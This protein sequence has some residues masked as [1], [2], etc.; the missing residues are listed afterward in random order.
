MGLVPPEPGFLA[1]LREAADA[2]GALLV[3]DEVISGFRVARGGAQEREGVTPDLTRA[4][5]DHRRRAAGRG[6]CRAARSDGADRAGGRRLPGGHA[7]GQPAGHRGRPRHAAPA[8]RRRLRAPG[9]AS[10]SALAD[11]PRAA[12]AAAGVP[13]QVAHTTGLL[14]LFFSDGA[15]RDYADAAALRPRAPT[16]PSAARMLDARGVPAAVAVRGLVPVARPRRRA[17]RAHARR[18]PRGV[19]GGG[20]R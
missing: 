12:A 9:R 10:R 6:L 8:R 19:R 3:F 13:V 2:A 15:G 17:R 20:A 14:T 18:R 16:P 1:F 5:Q 7:V 4:R 11:G